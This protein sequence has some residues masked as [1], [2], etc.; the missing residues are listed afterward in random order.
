MKVGDYVLIKK[1][2]HN[3]SWYH[4]KPMKILKMEHGVNGNIITVDYNFPGFSNK[5]NISHIEVYNNSLRN[6]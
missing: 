2:N 3:M 6:K 1:C 5:I 4:T